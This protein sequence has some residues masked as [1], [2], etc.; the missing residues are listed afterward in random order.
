MQA[1]KAWQDCLTAM[2]GMSAGMEGEESGLPPGE[3]ELALRRCLD[4][5]TPPLGRRRVLLQ[6]CGPPLVHAK[7]AQGVFICLVAPH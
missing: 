3:P 2:S 6:R 1:C 5:R 4:A 7:R